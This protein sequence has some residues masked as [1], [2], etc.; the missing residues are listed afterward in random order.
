MFPSFSSC[1]DSYFSVELLKLNMYLAAVDYGKEGLI[2]TAT[3][4]LQEHVQLEASSSVINKPPESAWL[5]STI[6]WQAS[7]TAN[8][9]FM[10]CLSCN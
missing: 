7:V 6:P 4:E 5:G 2:F 8:Q 9:W 3:G 10:V 1:T